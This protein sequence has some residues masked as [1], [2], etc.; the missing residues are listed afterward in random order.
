MNTRKKTRDA[1]ADLLPGRACGGL[2]RQVLE[3]LQS[4]VK[5]LA[6]RV[7][8]PEGGG[9]AVLLARLVE[10]ISA[11][12]WLAL[13]QTHNLRSWLALPLGA[14]AARALG[15][16][17]DTL[18]KLVFQRDHDPL[19][20]LAN[21]RYME[22]FLKTEME[23]AERTGSALSL[24]MLDLDRFKAVNDTYGHLCGDMVLRKMGAF[25]QNSQ[26]SY[27]LAA[28]YGGEEF[29]IILPGISFMRA[30][31]TAERLLGRFSQIEFECEA[32]PPFHMTFSAGVAGLSPKTGYKFSPREFIK[33]ADEALYAAKRA[34][35][36]RIEVSTGTVEA[37][38]D[39]MVLAEEKQ[40]LF[41]NPE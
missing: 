2:D 35:R 25:L 38:A 1:K 8:A 17:T 33:Q 26:R 24:I 36:N 27:D 40:F 41:K 15:T 28:R 31:A 9:E 16:L 29:M 4:V 10:G 30:R 18:D 34:G 39:T 7:A 3:E 5:V 6:D 13:S 21:R 37:L 12:E 11:E 23:R 22:R 32:Q 19:T 20:G 14:D